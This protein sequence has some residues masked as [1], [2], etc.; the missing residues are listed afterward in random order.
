MERGTLPARYLDSGPAQCQL[1]VLYIA[2]ITK[3]SVFAVVNQKVMV[4]MPCCVSPTARN[5]VRSVA[6]GPGVCVWHVHET[7]DNMPDYHFVCCC[8]FVSSHPPPHQ[9]K[10]F[11]MLLRN[12]S[13][14]LVGLSWLF[15]RD[16][17][18][19]IMSVYRD[20]NVFLHSWKKLIRP[21][22]HL[23][24]PGVRFSSFFLGK[25][26]IVLICWFHWAT[27]ESLPWWDSPNKHTNEWERKT[28]V[29]LENLPLR[30]RICTGVTRIVCF[31]RKVVTINE[32][33][34]DTNGIHGLRWDRPSVRKD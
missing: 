31:F 15:E 12:H 7:D 27:T 28:G 6:V 14:V 8:C 13:R 18:T 11:R 30:I 22:V 1:I 17:N 10:V 2:R 23:K 29:Q 26:T 33:G 34:R 32:T 25:H 20:T 4:L 24:R 21:F 16:L 19:L 3:S 5:W 9:K